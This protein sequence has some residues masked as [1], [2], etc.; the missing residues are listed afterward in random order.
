MREVAPEPELAALLAK[1]DANGGVM[2]Y[3]F[4]EAETECPRE[5]LHRSAAL[6]GMAAIDRRIEHWVRWDEAKLTG[7]RVPFPVFWGTDDVEPKPLRDNAWSI[8]NVD[9]YKA[10][11]FHPPHSLQASAKETAELFA[12]INRH[13]L[14]DVPELAEIFSW[15]TDWSN[16][17]DEGHE[18][19]G[20]FF[21]TIRAA[22][23]GRFVVVG[24]SA[25]D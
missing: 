25:S 23:M 4:L 10:A 8:P 5:Q 7:E 17:F 18:W 6:A 21:W 13:V 22:G 12:G 9:G 2:D 16:Y 15:S 14:G 24:A 20:A 3:I 1:Y 19:W 11:F